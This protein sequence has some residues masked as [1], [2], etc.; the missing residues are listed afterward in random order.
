MALNRLQSIN[1]I[2]VRLVKIYKYI[3]KHINV[4]PAKMYTNG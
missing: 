2:K 3:Y 1:E 4:G